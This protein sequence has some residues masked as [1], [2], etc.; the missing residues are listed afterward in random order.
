M[1]VCVNVFFIIVTDYSIV[2]GVGVA[3]A[4]QVGLEANVARYLFIET[5]PRTAA[6]G[7]EYPKEK[8]KHEVNHFLI[9]KN[10]VKF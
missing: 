3:K 8:A 2:D 4:V 1:F 6:S 5:Y 9:C 7:H 10:S